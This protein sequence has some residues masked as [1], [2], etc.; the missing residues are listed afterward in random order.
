M[1]YQSVIAW[2]LLSGNEQRKR[3]GLEP[4]TPTQAKDIWKDLHTQVTK[5]PVEQAWEI[6]RV[7]HH[8]Y[9]PS[10]WEPFGVVSD[11]GETYI[12][13]K[14]KVKKEAP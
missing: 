7:Q 9:E 12:W 8:R 14:R 2:M 1:I 6:K 5:L 3:N 4:I 11:M 10:E 13:L